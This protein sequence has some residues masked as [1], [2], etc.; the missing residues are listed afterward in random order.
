MGSG[1]L[2]TRTVRDRRGFGRTLG[3][4]LVAA[5]VVALLGFGAADARATAGQGCDA[6]AYSLSLQSLT[7]PPRAD[8]VI[9]I[10]TATP[11]CVLPE[12]LDDVQIAIGSRNLDVQA[13]ASPA[14]VATVHLGRVPRLQRVSA[15]VTFGP[16]ITLSGQTRTLLKPDLV[17]KAVRG[18]KVSLSGRAFNLT[19]TV[20]ERTKDIAPT[21]TVTVSAAGAVV[22][23]VSARVARRGQASLRVPVTLAI[24]GRNRLEVSVAADLPESTVANNTGRKTVEVTE[25][26]VTPANVLVQSLAGYGGQFNH[27]VYAQISRDVGVTD[28]NVGDMEQKMKAL[29]PEFSRIF[30]TL[31]AFDDP[32]RMQS[33][34]RTVLLAQ[35]AG[36][37]INIT[38]Q[39]GTLDVKGGNIQRFANVLIDLVRHRGVTNLRWLTLQNEPNRTRLTPEQVEAAY[40]ELDPY[41]QSIRGQVKYMGGDLVRGPG[42]GN[43]QQLWFDYMAQ[44]MADILDAWSIHVFWDYWDTQKLQDRLYEV[45]AIWDAEPADQRKP[46]YVTEYGVRGLRSF[47]GVTADPGF[48]Q[49]GTPMSQTNVSAFQHA[50][51]D[52][53]SSKLGYVGTS[54]WDSY[55]GKY[56]TGTQSYYMIGD[57]PPGKRLHLAVWNEAGDGVVAPSHVVVADAAGVVTITVPQHG[58]FVLTTIRLA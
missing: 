12:T 34:V 4:A 37:T 18:P 53:L 48:W 26:L 22:G 8:L 56:D 7:G 38:W 58:V 55:F 3:A 23:T 45:R 15:T 39:G 36:T 20:R 14:G 10:T 49:D 2:L 42:S 31:R 43:N 51:F 16:Q 5:L 50:W 30:F 35:T 6:S 13:V 11:E 32:D 40:R 57:P 47:N 41:I 24:P 25:F 52:V 28:A 17:L 21:A 46:L 44:H 1:M 29:H 9:R 19:V 54:K 27:H 33:F